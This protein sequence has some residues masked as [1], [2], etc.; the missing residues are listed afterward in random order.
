MTEKMNG[1]IC[2]CFCKWEEHVKGRWSI[3]RW[4]ADPKTV[5]KDGCKCIEFKELKVDSN[6]KNPIQSV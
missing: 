3:G 1:K 4:T 2:I 6:P 5:D